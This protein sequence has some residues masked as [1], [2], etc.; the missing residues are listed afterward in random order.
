[1][2]RGSKIQKFYGPLDVLYEWFPM[3]SWEKSQFSIGSIFYPADD[4]LKYRRA[5]SILTYLLSYLNTSCVGQSSMNTF[6]ENEDRREPKM[7]IS[8]SDKWHS[9]NT[10]G[11]TVERLPATRSSRP[12]RDPTRTAKIASS[13]SPPSPC[14]RKTQSIVVF[15]GARRNDYTWI[16]KL[17][18]IKISTIIA[19]INLKI[20]QV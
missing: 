2:G 9:F 14:R 16:K 7:A 6:G 11:C 8:N 18:K 12:S 4:I 20:G 15:D 3:R 17:W 1:M 13:E 19:L 5:I 10:H